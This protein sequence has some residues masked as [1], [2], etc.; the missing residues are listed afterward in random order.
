M[1][2]AVI[3]TGVEEEVGGPEERQT[4]SRTL[5]FCPKEKKALIASK[6]KIF[7]FLF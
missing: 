4:K 5:E 3:D 1:I 7:V 6:T 2:P